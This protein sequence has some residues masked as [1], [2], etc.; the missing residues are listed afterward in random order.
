[1]KERKHHRGRRK[2][3]KRT[4][5]IVTNIILVIAIAVFL[6]SGYKLYGIFSEYGKG[7]SEY[8]SIQKLAITTV[9]PSAA[10]ENLPEETFVVDF[11]KLKE[12]NSDVVGWIQ[13]EEPSQISYPLVKGTDNDKYLTTTFEGNKNSAGAL[14]L[15]MDNEGD[16]SDRNTFIYGHNM[17]N[18]SMFGRLRKYK[19]SSFCEEYPYFYIYTPDGKVSKYEVFS[20][21]IVKDTSESYTKWFADDAAFK[22]YIDYIRSISLYQTGAEVD[23]SSKIVSLSTCT[24]VSDDERM[25]VHGVKVS[26]EVVKQ[27]AEE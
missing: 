4:E 24:N 8:N 6:F 20:V 15:D 9:V 16:F 3:E 14:F 25:L 23:A 17:K 27:A 2:K 19:T 7:E 26:E 1:M 13:F 10:E 5:K 21:C 22:D 12:I 11:E 18:G